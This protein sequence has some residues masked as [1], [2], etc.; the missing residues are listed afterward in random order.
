VSVLTTAEGVGDGEGTL[1]T[2]ASAVKNGA[3]I[4]GS[5]SEGLQ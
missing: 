1:F 4:F 3:E 5:Y 2:L